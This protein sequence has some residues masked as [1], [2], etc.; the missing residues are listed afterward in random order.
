MVVR[1]SHTPEDYVVKDH[2]NRNCFMQFDR[3]I[4]ICDELKDLQGVH[5]PKPL[6]VIDWYPVTDLVAL[7]MSAPCHK[8][9]GVEEGVRIRINF[10]T[11]TFVVINTDL[12][13]GT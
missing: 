9:A 10:N 11:N 6:R 3:E 1:V 12:H 4:A 7:V 13:T 2:S 8:V 5:I